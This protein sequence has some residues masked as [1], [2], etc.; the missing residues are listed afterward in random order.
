L[1]NPQEQAA[2]L[3]KM[4]DEEVE[5]GND[6]G[7]WDHE[8]CAKDALNVVSIC[9]SWTDYNTKFAK[10]LWHLCGKEDWTKKRVVRAL[11]I[12]YEDDGHDCNTNEYPDN[13]LLTVVL[14]LTGIILTFLCLT[15][16][17]PLDRSFYPTDADAGP[18]FAY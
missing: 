5:I 7:F 1:K 13:K 16:G 9:S 14:G 2:C 4:M 12:A 11:E 6:Y 3:R 8:G 10:V 18:R 15:I 17:K